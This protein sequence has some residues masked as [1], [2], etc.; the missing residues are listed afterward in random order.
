M[1]KWFVINKGANL[2]K[3]SE[4]ALSQRVLSGTVR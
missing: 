4:S 3:S 1:E 2:E